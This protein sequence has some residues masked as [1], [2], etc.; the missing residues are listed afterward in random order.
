MPSTSGFFLASLLLVPSVLGWSGSHGSAKAHR[1]DLRA[2]RIISDAGDLNDSYDFIIAGGGTAGM[3]LAAR[4]TED[5]NHTV[6]VLEAGQ[7]GLAVGNSIGAFA[8]PK[9]RV[10][11]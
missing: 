11:C 1:R 9:L 7:S 2:R 4:L 6:L 3:V 8:W 5:S 10:P